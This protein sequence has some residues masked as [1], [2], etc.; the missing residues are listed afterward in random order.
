MQG[1]GEIPA[2]QQLFIDHARFMLKHKMVDIMKKKAKYA[3]EKDE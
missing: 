2:I 1:L 3:K